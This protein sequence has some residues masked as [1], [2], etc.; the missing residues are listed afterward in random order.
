M[1]TSNEN[2]E[3][4]RL[5]WKILLFVVAAG[6]WIAG[7]ATATRWLTGSAI[8]V[9]AAAILLRLLPA[10]MLDDEPAGED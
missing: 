10:G 1:P 9:L 6:L 8:V 2:P 5:R 7:A 4:D 3:R